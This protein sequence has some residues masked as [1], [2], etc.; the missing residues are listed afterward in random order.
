[1]N[2]EYRILRAIRCSDLIHLSLHRKYDDT[3]WTAGV[4]RRGQYIVQ[5][6]EDVD[7]LEALSKAISTI[8][9]KR[10]VN[11]DII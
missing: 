2:L 11:D 9:E 3:T 4:M 8:P 7:P 5:Y 6:V 1:M 10:T